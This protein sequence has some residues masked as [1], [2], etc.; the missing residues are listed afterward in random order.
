MGWQTTPSCGQNSL[1][2]VKSQAEITPRHAGSLDQLKL[3]TGQQDLRDFISNTAK[4]QRKR[5]WAALAGS[6]KAQTECLGGMRI[7]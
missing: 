3:T 4:N 2:F 1:G 6:N 5:D 7:L